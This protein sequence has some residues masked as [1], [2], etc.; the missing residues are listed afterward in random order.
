MPAA[1]LSAGCGD[2]GRRM[3]TFMP[4]EIAHLAPGE[5]GIAQLAI[6]VMS[7]LR[8]DAAHAGRPPR[9]DVLG[10]MVRAVLTGDPEALGRLTAEFRRL[11][12]PAEVVVDTYIPAAVT[13]IGT[14]WHEDVIDILDATIAMARLQNLVREFG[15]GWRADDSDPAAQGSVLMVV[16]PGESHT[17]GAM[18]A[19]AQLR[20]SGVSVAVQLAP[21]PAAIEEL[22]TTRR[23][24]ALFLS[25]GSVECL[26]SGAT[27]VKTMERRTRPRLPVVVGGS[28]PLELVAVRR[29]VG[30]D[31]ATR[32]VRAALDFLGLRAARYMAM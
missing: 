14:A 15:R 3:A 6:Q 28:I 10:L 11:R 13:E 30:A 27:I 31:F 20:R 5:Q 7:M 23:F 9:A 25:V 18:I 4:K 1:I 19:T 24:D 17:L 21:A 29:A 16:P 2:R 32:D 22:I 12:I 26:E 8:G